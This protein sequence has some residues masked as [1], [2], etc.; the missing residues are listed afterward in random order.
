M[1]GGER[2]EEEEEKKNTKQRAIFMNHSFHSRL[3]QICFIIM[4]Y[5]MQLVTDLHA[6]KRVGKYF[7][8]INLYT[9]SHVRSH[10]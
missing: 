6:C 1:R 8:G 5:K 4:V 10:S 9:L 2:E 7:R 3:Y